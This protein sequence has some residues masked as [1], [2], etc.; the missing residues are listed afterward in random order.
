MAFSKLPNSAQILEITRSNKLAELNF[1]SKVAGSRIAW[2]QDFSLLAK[3][4][5]PTENS[6]S[7]P[8]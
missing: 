2:I 3:E 1:S 8:L 4:V 7:F 5:E 6:S